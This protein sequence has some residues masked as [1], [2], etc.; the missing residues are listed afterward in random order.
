MKSEKSFCKLI[1]NNKL[2]SIA[3]LMFIL[4]VFKV[5]WGFFQEEDRYG[6]AS[7]VYNV[8]NQGKNEFGDVWVYEHEGNRC[9]T[10][11]PPGADKVQ[12]CMNLKH[13]NKLV[14]D[15]Y[16]LMMVAMYFKPE[17]H[18]VLHL[19]LGGGMVIRSI[20]VINPHIK[21]DV[22][23]INPLVIEYTD[24]YFHLKDN[25]I[26]N[27]HNMD[28]MEFVR[29]AADKSYDMVWVDVFDDDY[30]P[31]QFLTQE[32]SDHLKRITK[33]SAVITVNTFALSE[34]ERK[35]HFKEGGPN[36]D[37]LFAKAFDHSFKLDSPTSSNQIIISIKGNLPERVDLIRQSNILRFR[38]AEIGIN[39]QILLSYL[40]KYMDK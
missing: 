20:N 24:K 34:E 1:K 29:G 7:S 16:R 22:V 2:A 18:R 14:F 38:F 13:N 6:Q 19:G 28:A 21:Q 31:Q 3:V 35:K 17:P 36:E 39:Q 10:F 12:A 26:I 9:M 37:E 4:I 15:T 25:S 11:L 23:E 40:L 33:D 30:I 27:I 5:S 32:F 8:L